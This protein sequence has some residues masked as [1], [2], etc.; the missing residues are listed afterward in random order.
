VGEDQPTRNPIWTTVNWLCVIGL[1]ILALYW[2]YYPPTS[3][4]GALAFALAAT[5]MPLF[6]ERITPF[7]KMAW[8]GMLFALLFIEYRAIDQDH[9]ESEKAQQL[10][11]TRIGAGFQSVLQ[12]QQTDFRNVIGNEERQFDATMRAFDKSQRQEG[13]E[14]ARV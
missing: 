8:V 10:E 13:R 7:A 4:K 6:W 5:I 14:F 1:F 3:G 2:K 9:Q 11:L 12:Q